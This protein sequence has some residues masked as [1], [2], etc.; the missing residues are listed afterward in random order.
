MTDAKPP[1]VPPQALALLRS[2][3]KIEAIKRVVDSN[4][5]IGLREAKDAV[6]RCLLQAQEAPP[7]AFDA[8]TD[9]M[10]AEPAR[11]FPEAARAAIR[12]GNMIVAIKIVRETYALDLRESKRLVEA[13]AERGDAALADFDLSAAAPAPGR[14]GGDARA[15]TTRGSL[16]DSG[17]TV[18]RGDR[19]GGLWLAALIAAVAAATVW[20]FFGH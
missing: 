17:R 12:D 5:G 1:F 16:R 19:S 15:R 14:A 4:P 20:Y 18:A 13:Y 2:G 6:E 8:D 7:A 11:G 3:H 10:A 9:V